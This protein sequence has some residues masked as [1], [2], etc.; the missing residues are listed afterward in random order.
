MRDVAVAYE[1]IEF[2]GELARKIHFAERSDCIAEQ[3]ALASKSHTF[4]EAVRQRKYT[5]EV[6]LVLGH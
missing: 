6:Y 2:F 4:D 1:A 5:L 3:G